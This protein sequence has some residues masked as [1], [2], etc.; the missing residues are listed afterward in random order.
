MSSIRDMVVIESAGGV[1]LVGSPWTAAELFH[2]IT[3]IVL[4]QTMHGPIP[5]VPPLRRTN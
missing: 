3:T 5:L 1:R 2:V 4:R